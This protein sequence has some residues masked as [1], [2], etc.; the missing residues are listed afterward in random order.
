MDYTGDCDSISWRE[1]VGESEKYAL[2][3]TLCLK[4]RGSPV[5][6]SA[7]AGAARF[8]YF[9]KDLGSSGVETAVQSQVWHRE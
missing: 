5:R 2:T 8:H 6:S 7:I 4:D 3:E 9:S 1:M